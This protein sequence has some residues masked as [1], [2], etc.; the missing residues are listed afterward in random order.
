ML[1]DPPRPLVAAMLFCNRLVGASDSL[2]Q[3]SVFPISSNP[4]FVVPAAANEAKMRYP[5]LTVSLWV[6]VGVT[7][8]WYCWDA[9]QYYWNEAHLPVTQEKYD[10][11]CGR[12]TSECYPEIGDMLLA[13]SLAAR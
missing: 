1:I 7:L 4:P 10:A 5:M 2:A 13:Y 6:V 9:A 11:L 3:H 12:N 8:G